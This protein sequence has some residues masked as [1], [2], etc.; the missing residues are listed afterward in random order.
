M[1][2]RSRFRHQFVRRLLVE[3]ELPLDD[4]VQLL[5]LDIG[6][7]SVDGGNSGSKWVGRFSPSETSDKNLR[8]LSNM[9]CVP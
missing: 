2:R 6:N 7:R 1:L 8:K 4:G 3:P 5:A 9:T